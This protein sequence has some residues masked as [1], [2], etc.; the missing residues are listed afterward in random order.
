MR[1]NGLRALGGLAQ[2]LTSGLAKGRGASIA[3]LRADWPVIVGAELARCTRPEALTAGRGGRTGGRI[4]RLRVSGPAALEVQHRSG[5]IVERLNG[6]LG[7]GQVEAVRLVQGAIPQPPRPTAPPAPSPEIAQRMAERVATVQDPGLRAALARLGARIAV[8]RRSTLIALV[9]AP[10]AVSWA[11][12]AARAEDVDRLL[13]PVA[14]DHVLGNAD[15]PNTIIDYFSMT[16]PH[17][18]NFHA[19]VLPA[20]RR[21]WIDN[22]RARFIYR[23]FPLDSV[24]THASQLTECAGPARFFELVDLLFRN[25]TDWLTGLNP[26]VEMV[27]LLK[28]SGIEQ[29]AACLAEDRHLD[30]VLADVQ[31]GQ[32]LG[33]RFTPTVFINE[34]N[35][36][37][38]Q[39]GAG[40]ID[41]ILN[42]VGR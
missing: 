27:S 42:Q 8:N 23:H 5:E 34:Q 26:E 40:A 11:R 31:S 9:G 21:N 25:Q 12:R 41:S 10:F 22:G 24:A 33:V 36:G 3:R 30:K 4:L 14:G 2:R 15:A 38:A 16:C 35:Y 1:E 19:A 17:C 29:A 7:R 18:A 28:K 6:Y 39:G 32:S 20:V 13:A 37:P